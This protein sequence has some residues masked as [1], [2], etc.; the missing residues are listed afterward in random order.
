MICGE[1]SLAC[2]LIPI[3]LPTGTA[4]YTVCRQVGFNVFSLTK[5][6]N[7]QQPFASY[8]TADVPAIWVVA[9][10]DNPS[11]TDDYG[12]QIH[13]FSTKLYRLSRAVPLSTDCSLLR[14]F[15]MNNFSRDSATKTLQQA[16]SDSNAY[17]A[18]LE[19]AILPIKLPTHIPL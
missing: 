4:F 19:T 3:R 7:S 1:P 14:F 11:R 16:I 12:V 15:K 17:L 6:D 18:I 5:T 2:N 9:R 10:A 13:C 8:G